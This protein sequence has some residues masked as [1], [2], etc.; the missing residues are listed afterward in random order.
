[1]KKSTLFTAAAALALAGPLA[2]SSASAQQDL[3]RNDEMVQNAQYQGPSSQAQDRDNRDE[4]R[5]R[6]DARRGDHRDRRE[7]WRDDNRELRWDDDRHNGY[8]KTAAGPTARRPRIAT[9]ARISSS[10]IAL[11]RSVNRSATTTA[12]SSKWTIAA[13]NCAGRRVACAG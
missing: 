11:G 1:M 7:S 5:D 3:L 4:T 10:A 12:A 8:Y 6:D 13:R 2:I 9:A